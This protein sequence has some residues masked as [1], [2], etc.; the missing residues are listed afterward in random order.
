VRELI[1]RHGPYQ[2]GDADV[3]VLV[4]R[5]DGHIY[6]RKVYISGC[7]KAVGIDVGKE[8]EYQTE[9]MLRELCVAV[10]K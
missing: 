10:A 3:Y 9:K 4:F 8:L 2:D 6:V 7:A 5:V 1:A